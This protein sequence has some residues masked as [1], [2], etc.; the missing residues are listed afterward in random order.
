VVR[1]ARATPPAGFW[2]FS[3]SVLY[4][5]KLGIR[6]DRAGVRCVSCI[7]H[8][9]AAVSSRKC[10]S[11]T[12]LLFTPLAFHEINVLVV[13]FIMGWVEDGEEFFDS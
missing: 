1:M 4:T 8:A 6:K 12:V 7:R 2:Q 10:A 5:V 3:L 11:S 9:V 13:L